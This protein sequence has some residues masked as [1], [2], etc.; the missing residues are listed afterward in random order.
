MKFAVTVLTVA[1]VLA[2]S[3]SARAEEPQVDN[4]V[5]AQVNNDVI[6]LADYVR[7][8]GALR[9]ELKL[10]MKGKS[11]AE[12]EAELDVRKSDLLDSMVDDLLLEQRSK[13][14]GLDNDVDAD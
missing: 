13:E 2:L 6:T 5:V 7:E 14:L 3:S 1:L 8:Q 9:E 11:D 10:Q 12:V 4:Y